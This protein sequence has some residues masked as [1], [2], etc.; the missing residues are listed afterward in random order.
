MRKLTVREQIQRRNLIWLAVLSLFVTG[1]FAQQDKQTPPVDEDCM[2]EEADY[3]CQP[4]N[5]QEEDFDK[6]VS[7]V[8]MERDLPALVELELLDSDDALIK[9]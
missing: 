4:T 8:P 2:A 9:R 7:T 6:M 5:P 3:D 1:V